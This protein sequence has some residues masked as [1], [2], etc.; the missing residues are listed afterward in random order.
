ME[1]P[2]V[3]VLWEGHPLSAEKSI[4]LAD[5]ADDDFILFPR[6]VAP[7]V[8]DEIREIFRETEVEP[9]IIMEAQEWLT[10]IGLVQSGIGVSI[11]PA[12]FE[13]L[14]W[15][16]VHYVGLSDVSILT[17]VSV[18][19]PKKRVT[20]AASRFLEMMC[21]WRDLDHPSPAAHRP[22]T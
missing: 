12:S 4:R 17:S 7:A 21:K 18:C 16:D 2:F 15:D 20:K 8:H 22:A 1:E 5:L 10:I 11:A 9:T 14:R 6:S 19:T 3:A 13:R